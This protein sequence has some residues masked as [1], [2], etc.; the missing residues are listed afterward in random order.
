MV[1]AFGLDVSTAA[2]AAGAGAPAF[3]PPSSAFFRSASFGVVLLLLLFLY[4]HSRIL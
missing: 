2:P 3:A 1:T 4:M